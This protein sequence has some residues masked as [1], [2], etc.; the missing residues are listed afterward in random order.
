M[1]GFSPR[2]PADSW[3][4]WSF[5]LVHTVRRVIVFWER[6]VFFE[7]LG[8]WG[9]IGRVRSSLFDSHGLIGVDEHA[10]LRLCDDSGTHQVAG[11]VV[12]GPS[13]VQD[14]VDACYQGDRGHRQS[15]CTNG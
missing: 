5:R 6:L 7:R 2:N 11:D 8:P 15:Y 9:P 1:R 3:R 12:H 13:H 10:L 4:S 14:R